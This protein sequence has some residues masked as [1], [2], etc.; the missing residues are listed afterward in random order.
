MRRTLRWG[1]AVLVAVHGL[2]HLLGAAEGL[3]WA[4]VDELEGPTSAGAGMVWLAAA[5]LVLTA[6]VMTARRLRG[7]WLALAAAALLSQAVV[8]TSWADAKV[9]T[10]VNAVMLLAAVYGY[11]ADGP[12]SL[13]AEYGR[14]TREALTGL[15]SSGVVTE[16][17][18]ARL[19][20]PLATY[21]RR[22]GAV[23]RPK[24]TSFRATVH[25]RIR[26]GP[27][28]AWMS[29]T[30]QQVNTLGPDPSRLFF[31]DATMLG[32][33]VDILHTFSGGAATMR[34][35]LCSLVPLLEASGADMT[36]AETVTVFNDLCIMAPAALPDASVTWNA[37]D[38][39]AV[40][41]T[42]GLG[43]QEVSAVLLFNED[44]DLVD[45]VSEDRLRAS[46]DGESFTRLGW[47]TPVGHYAAFEGRL[48][49]TTG[50]AIWD[51]PDP[52]GRFAY[53]EFHIDDIHY[54][55]GRQ[56]P[57]GVRRH[58]ANADHRRN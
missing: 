6:S 42:F 17:E 9:G 29:F 53:L 34:G 7:W 24:V 47:S 11:R 50:Q 20:E 35:R 28:K 18:V 56:A 46:A 51:A 40:R 44:G 19:P 23:G 12:A 38:S 16:R 57:S 43:H 33:P 30:G 45:F 39:H 55:V 48:V 26:G 54:D 36:R 32:L 49:A 2:I 8:V 4:E 14:Q 37:V 5:G 15:Q 1:F 22:A 52:E 13:R 58:L 41:G 21:V 31:M 25:G 27:D 10:V 3:R